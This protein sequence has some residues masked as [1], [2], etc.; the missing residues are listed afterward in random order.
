MIF[1]DPDLAFFREAIDSV[2]GQTFGDLELLLV[3]DGSTT[4]S[5]A[6]ARS[7]AAEQP[8]RVV[9]LEHAKHENRGTGPSRN[10]GVRHARGELVAFL[11]ADDV[12][13]P[14][15][16]ERQVQ[17]L[18]DNPHAQMVVGGT[19]YWYSWA[20]SPDQDDYDQSVGP[21]GVVASPELAGDLLHQRIRTPS[22]TATMARLAAVEQVGAFEDSFTSHYEDQAFHFKFFLEHP[23]LFHDEIIDLYRQHPNS[24]VATGLAT[25]FFHP[26]APS[27]ARRQY[28]SFAARYLGAGP[29]AGTTLHREA[30]WLLKLD[31]WPR[32][33]RY[34]YKLRPPLLRRAREKLLAAAGRSRG[35]AEPSSTSLEGGDGGQHR[36]SRSGLDPRAGGERSG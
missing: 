10:V 32:V 25:G 12:W 2:L 20:D 18:D 24:T 4:A 11:D 36:S 27:P 5:T 30:V 16:L 14:E 15:A 34:V 23:V 21:R 28:R 7:V 1:L 9:Y 26:L 22:L 33:G 8:D 17:L 3:D 31:R 6:Y 35:S 19:R 29:W 13:V